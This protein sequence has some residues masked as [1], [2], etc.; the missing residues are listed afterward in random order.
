MASRISDLKLGVVKISLKNF[1]RRD[2]KTRKFGQYWGVGSSKKLSP[3]SIR[4]EVFWKH[5]YGSILSKDTFLLP[6]RN[7][8][9][10]K[11]F[12]KEANWVGVWHYLWAQGVNWTYI[13]RSENILGVFWTSVLS[14]LHSI[15]IFCPGGNCLLKREYW[16]YAE[17]EVFRTLSIVWSRFNLFWFLEKD[18]IIYV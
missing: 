10:L 13:R 12:E 9:I 11:F 14:Y 18:S 4:F 15:H 7:F 2:E 17:H 8:P 1:C 6:R 3:D 16:I 5:Y